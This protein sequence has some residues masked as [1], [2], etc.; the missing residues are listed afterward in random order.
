MI[1]SEKISIKEFYYNDLFRDYIFNFKNI[2]EFY[3]Y[4]YR[5]IEHYKKRILDIKAGYDE[6]NRLRLYDILKSYNK[7]IGCSN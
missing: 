5:N 1:S 3:E 7:N 6:K 2:R 4:D